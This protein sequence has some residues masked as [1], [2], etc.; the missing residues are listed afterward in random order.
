ME[1][2]T[3]IVTGAS[4]G[5][6]FAIAQALA[7]EGARV[8][9]ASRNEERGT[10]AAEEIDRS[11]AGTAEFLA[12]DVS[13]SEEVRGAVESI[14]ERYGAIHA[15][16]NNAGAHE[17]APFEEESAEL[18]GHMYRTNVL[19]T[20]L[21]SQ[22]V[23]PVM[24][25]QGDGSIVHV[26]SKAG[27]VGEPGHAA[28][29]ASKGAVIGLTRAMAVELGEHGIRVNNIAPGPVHTAM[30]HGA[31]P[32]PA[33][34]D[35]IAAEAPMRRVGNPEDIGQIAVYLASGESAWC[36]GQTFCIDGGLS[37]LK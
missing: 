18:W 21:P 13:E 29:S 10:R 28:Y 17:G 30:F 35:R 36:T 22:A 24:R 9:I 31:V 11:A 33:A 37:V 1:A 6:G 16:V 12:L 15:L 34:R 8:V 25:A 20:V 19:G 27:V 3:V 2:R 32:D 26:S 23:V 14:A 7:A 5:I 4:G